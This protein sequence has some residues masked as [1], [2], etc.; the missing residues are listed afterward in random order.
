MATEH[1]ILI[2][3]SAID[4][5]SKTLDNISKRLDNLTAPVG[6]INTKMNSMTSSVKKST[7]TLSD[8]TQ[9]INTYVTDFKKMKKQVDA[10]AQAI[11]SYDEALSASGLTQKELT[12]TLSDF[13][14]KQLES[15]DFYD[16]ITGR[17][18]K[19]NDAIKSATIQ[20]KRFKFEFL[21]ILFLGMAMDRVFGSLI[22][23]QF[24]LWGISDLISAAWQTV[25]APIMEFVSAILFPLIEG[26]MNLPEP[27]KLVIGVLVLLG[28]V[29]GKVFA[30]IGTLY[31]GVKAIS[32]VF[33]VNLFKAIGSV[34]S[35]LQTV[36]TAVIPFI[37]P[38]IAIII[39]VIDIFRNWGKSVKDVVGGIIIVL[40]GLA[41]IIAVLLGAPALLVAA[42]VAA[43][44]L[45][46][47]LIVRYWEQIRDFFI[48][49]WNGLSAFFISVWNNLLEFFR[50]VFVSIRTTFLETWEG[51]KSFF[52][53]IWNAIREVFRDVIYSMR[54]IFLVVWNG[55]KTFFRDI[56]TSI[57]EIF[58]NSW[59]GIRD[60]FRNI[61]T[62]MRDFVRGIWD[63]IV[64]FTRDKWNGLKTFFAGLWN[65]IKE[66]FGNAVNFIVTLPKRILDA[67]K[68]LGS[69]IKEAI[70]DIIPDWIIKILDKGIKLVGGGTKALGKLLGSFQT[71]GM[72]PETGPYL[73]H[74]G[75]E[76]IPRRDVQRNVGN[77]FAPIVT[78]NVGGSNASPDLIARQISEELNREWAYKFSRMVQRK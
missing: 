26:F 52:S 70:E 35:I 16:T 45:S 41:G 5:A 49:L 39:G 58:K 21:S 62:G 38:I 40:A 28:A 73:L 7:K 23:S 47:K 74:Q 61:V 46:V 53:G 2:T 55:I 60:F 17:T 57:T 30:T 29:I 75:E 54:D 27:I 64:S 15:K 4:E 56:N 72:V 33:G 14:L 51:L 10:T 6:D 43:V 24:E 32:A 3:I 77:T 31:L 20:A 50:N 37:V 1:E 18:I 65:G 76:V 66:I 59:N 48:E 13:N 63:S 8:G 78:V 71:G 34:G 11:P 69:R 68:N 22:K 42:I 12:Q 44:V 67:F 25:L 9:I 19:Y 36:F